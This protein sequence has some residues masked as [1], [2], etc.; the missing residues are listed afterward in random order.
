MTVL[1]EAWNKK[2]NPSG[3]EKSLIPSKLKEVQCI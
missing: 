1:T 3:A 2:E